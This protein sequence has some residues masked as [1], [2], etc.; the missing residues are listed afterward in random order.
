MAFTFLDLSVADDDGEL[1]D[2]GFIV[3][4][5][6]FLRLE[7]GMDGIGGVD[8]LSSS[9]AVGKASSKPVSEVTTGNLLLGVFG[10]ILNKYSFDDPGIECFQN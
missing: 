5:L 4:E 1:V 9:V 2:I 8:T 10:A 3:E 6:A 7:T